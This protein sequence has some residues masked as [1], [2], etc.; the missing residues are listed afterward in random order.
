VF[1]MKKRRLAAILLILLSFN[2]LAP[3][4]TK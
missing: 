4:N 2:A 1:Y 3:V